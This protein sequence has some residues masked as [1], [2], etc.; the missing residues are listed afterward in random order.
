MYGTTMNE[1][2]HEHEYKDEYELSEELDTR[3]LKLMS[4]NEQLEAK[5]EDR[6]KQLRDLIEDT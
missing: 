1:Y 3:I 6:K 5:L 4:E 2:E